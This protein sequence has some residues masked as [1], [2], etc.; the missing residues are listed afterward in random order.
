MLFYV[1]STQKRERTLISCT[2][3]IVNKR[4]RQ[5]AVANKPWL[6]QGLGALMDVLLTLVG[7]L[8]SLVRYRHVTAILDY[9][10]RVYSSA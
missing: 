5:C 9:Q 2:I 8:R 6:D 1:A 3:P 10:K 7:I 4:I